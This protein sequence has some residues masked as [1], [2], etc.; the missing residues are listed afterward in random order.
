MA[1]G[2][3]ELILV[4]QDLSFYG[5]DI[6]KKQRLA[7]LL[8]ALSDVQGLAWIRLHYAYPAGFPKDI[9]RVM[10]EKENICPYLDMPL[11]HGADTVLKEDA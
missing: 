10:A 4:A 2:V 11:Q 7:D 1:G 5:Y 8:R 3:K 6:Y 9:L